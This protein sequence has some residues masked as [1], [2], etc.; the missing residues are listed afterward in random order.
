MTGFAAL[1][2]VFLRDLSRRKLLWA[3]ALLTVGVIGVIDWSNRNLEEA[4]GQ[5]QAWDLA[6]REA[7]SQLDRLVGWLRPWLGF[8]VVLLAAQVAPESRRNGTSQFILSQGVRRNTLALAQYLALASVL[9]VGILILQGGFAVAGLKTGF[10]KP[11]E[12]A[13]SWLTLLGP[14]LATAAAVLA[15]SLTA[16]ALET[17]L[18]FLGIPFLTRILPAVTGGFPRGF[19]VPLARFVDNA[20]LFFPRFDELVLWPHLSYRGGEG[21][22]QPQWHWPLVHALAACLFWVILGVWLQR[23]HDFGSRTA[24]K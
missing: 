8:A 13:F 20:S 6:T 4:V 1:V 14:S 16:S 7:A 18:V 12:M 22:P 9:S 23:R 10:M 24:L 5:G 17:Y 21:P 15:V 11:A 19:P 2:G 3:L